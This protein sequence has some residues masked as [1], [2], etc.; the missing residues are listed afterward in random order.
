MKRVHLTQPQKPHLYKKNMLF[1]IK[2]YFTIYNQVYL[3]LYLRLEALGCILPDMGANGQRL[4]PHKSIGPR[5][6]AYLR[7]HHPNLRNEFIEVSFIDEN[8]LL[9]SDGKG[10]YQYSNIVLPTYTNYFENVWLPENAVEYFEARHPNAIGY[11]PELITVSED[12]PTTLNGSRFNAV[13][14]AEAQHEAKIREVLR[15]RKETS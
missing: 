4:R 10:N 1:F 14:A 8:G 13:R 12:L 15:N 6:D 9:D 11:L 2:G 7:D 3:N 5:F